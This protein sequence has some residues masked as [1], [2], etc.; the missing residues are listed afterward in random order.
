MK[1]IASSLGRDIVL[2]RQGFPDV[3]YLQVEVRAPDGIMDIVGFGKERKRRGKGLSGLHLPYQKRLSSH[4]DK[5]CKI[6]NF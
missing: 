3:L 1:W 4:N 6:R 2:L 5:L